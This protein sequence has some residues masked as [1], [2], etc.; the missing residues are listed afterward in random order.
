MTACF[1]G[2]GHSPAGVGSLEL[3]DVDLSI[4]VRSRQDATLWSLWL[5]VAAQVV[6]WQEA[7]INLA[8]VRKHCIWKCRSVFLTFWR[9]SPR[10]FW[11]PKGDTQLLF[12]HMEVWGRGS[13]TKQRPL[14]LGGIQRPTHSSV[15]DVCFD[16]AVPAEEL[17]SRLLH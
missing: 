14:L 6:Q 4:F 10:L 13:A 11:S 9:A 8:G 3:D 7:G 17:L 5:H 2:L 15:V 16:P 1:L 12:Y